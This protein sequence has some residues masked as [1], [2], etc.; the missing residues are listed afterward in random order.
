MFAHHPPA[1]KAAQVLKR[2]G[3]RIRRP[4]RVVRGTDVSGDF[5]D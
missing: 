2:A 4:V 5:V 1:E 3:R